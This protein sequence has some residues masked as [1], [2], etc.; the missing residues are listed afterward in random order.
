MLLFCTLFAAWVRAEAF[1]MAGIEGSLSMQDLAAHQGI[2]GSSMEALAGAVDGPAISPPWTVS[3]YLDKRS[4]KLRVVLRIPT[5]LL[6]CR[7]ASK[8]GR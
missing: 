3:C 8:R 1:R 5:V 7:Q 4:A 2:G 6:K